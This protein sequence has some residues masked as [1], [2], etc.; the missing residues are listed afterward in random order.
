M[1]EVSLT[2]LALFGWAMVATLYAFRFKA[3]RNTAAMMMQK[4]IQ[5]EGVRNEILKKYEEWKATQQA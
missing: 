5:D 1:I 2:E 3:E 4:L